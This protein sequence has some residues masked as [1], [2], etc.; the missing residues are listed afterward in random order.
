[1]ITENISSSIEDK[2]YELLKIL[3]DKDEK[4]KK[5][6]IIIKENEIKLLNMEYIL[7]DNEEKMINIENKFNISENE[8]NKF[9]EL[10]NKYLLNEYD[11]IEL[12]ENDLLTLV[13]YL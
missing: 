3:Q 9:R 1:M 11:K 5:M 8:N 2:N 7:K 10:L 4:I 6:E 13:N 12:N